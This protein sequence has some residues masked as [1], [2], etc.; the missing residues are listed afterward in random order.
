MPFKNR[1]GV[2]DVDQF[3]FGIFEGATYTKHAH[4]EQGKQTHVF[5]M[6]D[7]HE[8]RFT[9]EAKIQSNTPQEIITGLYEINAPLSLPEWCV[10]PYALTDSLTEG[11]ACTYGL[12][13]GEGLRIHK[14]VFE[15]GNERVTWTFSCPVSFY[16]DGYEI[17]EKCMRS[18]TFIEQNGEVA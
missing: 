14:A 11:W 15:N 3:R 18:F 10:A 16:Q 5:F 1:F 13:E 7:G 9:I 8:F 12:M 6:K 2:V 17:Y 4:G